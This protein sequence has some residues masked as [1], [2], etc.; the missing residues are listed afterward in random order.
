[1]KT[2]RWAAAQ[3]RSK[4]EVLFYLTTV[5]VGMHSIVFGLY[6]Y[7]FAEQ[8]YI[9]FFATAPEN[10]FFVRQTGVFLFCLGIYYF[11]PLLNVRR[12]DHYVFF[13]IITKIATVIFMI[14][15][16]KSS[17]SPSTIYLVALGDIIMAGLLLMT[18]SLHRKSLRRAH[19]F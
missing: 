14:L 10:L 9:F 4:G 11:I 19:L 17:M 18:F 5:L 2:L 13:T 7:F 1:M 12:I 8:F 16:A 6:I 3:E 15:N